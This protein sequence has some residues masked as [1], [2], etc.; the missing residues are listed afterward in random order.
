MKR[1]LFDCLCSPY[2]K[3]VLLLNE[4]HAQLEDVW[5]GVFSFSSR[6]ASRLRFRSSFPLW[7]L[8]AWVLLQFTVFFFPDFRLSFMSVFFCL[9][10]VLASVHC[11]LF[12]DSVYDI[13][14]TLCTYNFV[15]RI[16]NFFFVL[17][18]LYVILML[19]G[20]TMTIWTIHLEVQ[21]IWA[22]MYRT[23]FLQNVF[24]PFL[25]RMI[26]LWFDAPSPVST[27]SI[28]TCRH[29]GLSAMPDADRTCALIPRQENFIQD[30]LHFS[31]TNEGRGGSGDQGR[32]RGSYSSL[33]SNQ[34]SR[35]FDLFSFFWM[36]RW[37][38]S[39][40]VQH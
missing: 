8:F 22:N 20:S 4:F 12:M 23:M 32:E 5:T 26:L 18:L 35:A 29:A 16:T 38:V 33:L 40:I 27:E 6:R 31:R 11:F 13:S 36:L 30:K 34:R 15:S 7:C 39:F 14:T 25:L 21:A 28:F 2:L 3:Y 17:E 37:N 10:V 24:I 9:L 19:Y 1:L